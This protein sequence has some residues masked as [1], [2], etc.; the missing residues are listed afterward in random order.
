MRTS[1]NIPSLLILLI[2]VFLLI[3]CSSRSGGLKIVLPPDFTEQK[4]QSAAN[5]KRF[6]Q[7]VK[8][9][10]AIESAIE[11]SEKY[12]KLT[13]EAAELRQNN[14]NL[15]E[16][17]EK[18]KHR[19]SDLNSELQRTQKELNEANEL[20]MEMRVELNN[21][22]ADILGFREEMREAE[23]SQLEVLHKVVEILGGEINPEPAA[24]QDGES[25]KAVQNEPNQL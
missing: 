23:I 20:M 15:T 17:N 19:I 16:E 2:L 14:K 10:S 5:E 1:K 12:T 6:Q 4:P 11:I 9:S 8:G 24:E 18:L 21:W 7:P 25:V 3:G 22:K 13:E